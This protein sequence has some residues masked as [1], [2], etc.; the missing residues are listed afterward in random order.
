MGGG[1]GL[2]L[3][4]AMSQPLC[5]ALLHVLSCTTP[6]LP[7]RHDCCHFIELKTHMPNVTQQISGIQNSNPDLSGSSEDVL[8]VIL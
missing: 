3:Q 5:G 8:S 2:V 7:G 1:K 4:P 6:N